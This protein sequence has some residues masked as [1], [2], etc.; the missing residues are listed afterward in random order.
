[1][2]SQYLRAHGATGDAVT[3]KSGPIAA[4]ADTAGPV[5]AVERARRTE[6]RVGRR[7]REFPC[8][9]VVTQVPLLHHATTSL[10]AELFGVRIRRGGR[11]IDGLARDSRTSAQPT[12]GA[13]PRSY[14][15]RPPTPVA[16]RT[17]TQDPRRRIGNRGEVRDVRIRA[18]RRGLPRR[19]RLE[20]RLQPLAAACP[21]LSR[22]PCV[23]RSSVRLHSV[24]AAPTRRRAGTTPG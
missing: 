19:L 20:T 2:R 17:P 1:V 23:R 24:G 11:V 7:S 13:E 15:R 6:D 3:A 12:I 4:A 22:S 16:R 5:N 14:S 9:E 18:Y 10:S 21:N 8:R